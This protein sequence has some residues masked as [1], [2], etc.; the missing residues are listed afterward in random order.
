MVSKPPQMRWV[1][2]GPEVHWK[3]WFSEL[4]HLSSIK[5]PR[6]FKK[7]CDVQQTRVHVH[8]DASDSA[9]AAASYV[10]SGYPDGTVKVT[11]ALA[12]AGP[13][14]IRKCTIPKLELKSAVQGVRLSRVLEEAL[15]LPVKEPVFWTDSMNVL[16]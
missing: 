14:P 10:R 4:P 7:S 11:L 5:V 3:Q 2:D 1:C 6:C 15:K 13:S 9:Y 8:V 12:K 16:Y